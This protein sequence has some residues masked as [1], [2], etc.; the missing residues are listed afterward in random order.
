MR[1]QDIVRILREHEG[2]L[3]RAGVVSIS[4]FGSAARGEAGLDSD[5]DL[6]VRLG[7]EFSHGGFDYFGKIEDL[8]ARLSRIL[9]QSVDIVEEPVERRSLQDR[10]DGDRV[11]A[12]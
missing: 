5:V 11:R 12:F 1:R 4:L 7:A 8:K 3:R 9:G 6:A 2:E 10:I